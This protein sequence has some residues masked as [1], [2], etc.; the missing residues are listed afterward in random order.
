MINEIV[1]AFHRIN[2]FTTKTPVMTSSTLDEQMNCKCYFKCENFQK[3]GSFKFRG[4]INAVMLLSEEEKENGVI[5]HS[6]GNHAQAI[7]YAAKLHN[8]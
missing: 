6:T 3:T 5:T 8:I 2:K 7:A 1:N 4:A